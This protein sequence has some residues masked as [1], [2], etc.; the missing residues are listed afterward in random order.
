LKRRAFLAVTGAAAAGAVARAGVP[1]QSAA[2]RGAAGVPGGAATVH[3]VRGP[4]EASSMGTTLVHEHV[5]VDFAGAAVDNRSRYDADE[6]FET[7]LPH[8]MEL[9]KRGCR[10]F[11]ECTPA[12][13]GRDPQLLAR[14]SEASGL[15]IVTNTG[16]YGAAK[17]VAI[18]KH[19]YDETPQQLAARWTAELEN[20]I[21]GTRIRPGFVKIGVD[22][23][24]LSAIDLKLVEAGALCHLATGLTLAIHTGDGEAAGDILATLARLGVRG[25]AYVW[26]HAQNE[27]DPVLRAAVANKGAWVELD[28]V[29]PKTLDGH[30]AAVVDLKAR[31]FLGQVLVSQDAGWYHV[32]EPRGGSYRPYVF[33][34]DSFV[35]ALRAA[36]LTESDV[37]TLLVRNPAAAFQVRKR[38]TSRA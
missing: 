2:P 35:P 15:Q 3:T 1:G 37:E 30:V 13:L 32:G 17:D 28:G 26:V 12:H 29:S 27:K 14:L 9:R 34:F 18:P 19:A 38:P 10:T 25:E 20:G 5:L 33:L 23:G 8:L 24:P 16:Y 11:V 36:G 21:E 31:G 7:A 6:V 22:A 4:I